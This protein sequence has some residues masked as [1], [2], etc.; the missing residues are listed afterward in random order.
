[1]ASE[2]ELK[3]LDELIKDIPIE[4]RVPII[5]LKRLLEER[6]KIDKQKEEE[7]DSVHQKYRKMLEP[8]TKRVNR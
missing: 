3:Q 5:A 2:D 4:E 1:M 7:I 8:N 6:R